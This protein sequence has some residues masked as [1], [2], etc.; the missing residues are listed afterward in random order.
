[1][2]FRVYKVLIRNI[3]GML[4]IEETRNAT[5]DGFNFPVIPP[6]KPIRFTTDL[7]KLISTIF[8][9]IMSLERVARVNLILKVQ[10][11]VTQAQSQASTTRSQTN[12][13]LGM[14][15]VEMQFQKWK[16]SQDMTQMTNI[17]KRGRYKIFTSSWN[18]KRIMVPLVVIRNAYG[19]LLEIGVWS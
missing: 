4:E 19:I 14:K 1:M 16:L 3:N 2:D 6:F 13:S 9:G 5:F 8:I 12:A 17:L 7:Q 18:R 11:R 10:V 15:L